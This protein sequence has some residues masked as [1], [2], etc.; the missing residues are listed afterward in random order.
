MAKRD[1]YSE[2]GPL[3]SERNPRWGGF[4][5]R[6]L[7][8]VSVGFLA[9]L[10]TAVVLWPYMV[11][12]VPS[13]HVAVLWH[14][15]LSIDTYCWCFTDRG[16]VLN[17]RELRE[18]GLHIIMPWDKLYIYDLRLQSRPE[19]YHAISKDGVI[20]TAQINVRYQLLHD[21][22]GV[23]HK[24]VG[25]DYFDT[26]VSPEI[27]SQARQI[28][29]QYTAQEVYTSRDKIQT[30]IRDTTQRTLAEK[31]NKL[32][33]PAAMEESDPQ[34]YLDFMQESILI[35]DTLVLSIDLPPEIVAAIN[36]QTEQY[37]AI[38]EAKYRVQRE[39]AESERKMIEANGIAAF[40]RTVSKGISD[41]YLRW[42]GIN[43]T[44]ALAQSPNAKVVIIGS[45]KDGLP[46][47]LG[48]DTAATGPA[49]QPGA[50]AS[51]SPPGAAREGDAAASAPPH[52]SENQV[53]DGVGPQRA[54]PLLGAGKTGTPN[55]NNG[56]GSGPTS[57]G[58]NPSGALSKVDSVLSR[59][60]GFV[61]PT[62][63]SPPSQIETHSSP[64]RGQ[65]AR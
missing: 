42:Q 49:T 18:E 53:F 11:I 58:S 37:Y 20:V 41:S 59:I 40:Q 32:V 23:L 57:A 47:I 64:D 54:S 44:L 65:G 27:G 14:R 7:P 13:G 15:F 10:L 3:L 45:G 26:I 29:S 61:R 63:S 36:R 30:Q 48:N 50:G 24:F 9:L 55:A 16:T 31:L 28:I 2:G 33:Q 62:E 5:T 39:A 60:Y 25:P 46:I 17:P 8:S 35:L 6:F 34:H 12:T 22:V 19:V 38:Q 52:Q 1:E 51:L 56:S 4:F 43:A 21:A